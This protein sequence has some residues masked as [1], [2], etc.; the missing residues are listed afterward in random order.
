MKLNPDCMRAVLF[1]IESNQDMN[2]GTLEKIY[3]HKIVNAL[4]NSFNSDE[5]LY[6]IK[7]LNDSFY[8][9]STIFK[10]SNYSCAVIDITP[11]G[12][13]FINNVRNDVAWNQT[14]EIAKQNKSFSIEIL[15]QIANAIASAIAQAAIKTIIGS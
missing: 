11:R 8:L 1:Y 7:Q 9:K 13:E 10:T 12:H 2:C 14:K 3:S 6:S 5:I 15:G 4:N